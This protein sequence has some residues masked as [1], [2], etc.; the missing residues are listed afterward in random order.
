MPVRTSR[1]VALPWLVLAVCLPGCGCEGEPDTAIMVEID[2]DIPV[3]EMNRVRIQIDSVG[4]DDTRTNR[5]DTEYALL[6]RAAAE[7]GGSIPDRPEVRLPIRIAVFPRAADD[8]VIHVAAAGLALSGGD[9]T[10]SASARLAFVPGRSLLLRVHLYAVCVDLLCEEGET[11]I[12]VADAAVCVDEK[13]DRPECSLQDLTAGRIEGC[14]DPCSKAADCD[15]G[16]DCTVDLCSDGAC[17]HTAGCSGDTPECCGTECAACCVDGDCDDGLPCTADTC[18]AG[19]CGHSSI[20]DCVDAEDCG[21]GEC[22]DGACLGC[23]GDADCEDG[24]GCTDDVC[25]DGGCTHPD[26][27]CPDD[28]DACT[29]ETCADGV[30]GPVALCPVGEL[31]CDG[32]C[33]TQCCTEA[34]CPTELCATYP[35]EAGRCVKTPRPAGTPCGEGGVCNGPPKACVECLVEGDCDP[36]PCH[37]VACVEQ[38][39]AWEE[40]PDGTSCGDGGDQCCSGVCGGCCD[41]SDCPVPEGPCAIATCVEGICGDS[42]LAD[43][44]DCGAGL[45]CQEC[46]CQ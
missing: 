34:D 9:P 36:R 6:D 10:V 42:C 35:C 17:S 27:V 40:Q 3:E 41:V 7:Q 45:S 31:C 46:V 14:D 8:G 23:C 32:T 20:C 29:V 30:C 22:C 43:G 12:Q 24:D 11:C 13:I 18:E 16:S 38:S 15:D 26:H 37:V 21:G 25:V 2:S 28:G 44:T 5:L 39:C 1:T 19:G 4:P 33:G